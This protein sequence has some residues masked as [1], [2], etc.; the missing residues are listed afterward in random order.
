MLTRLLTP[1]EQRLQIIPE[2]VQ[3]ACKVADP[4]QT[5]RILSNLKAA[6]LGLHLRVK[7]DTLVAHSD[8]PRVIPIP[9]SI[10][11]LRA[12]ATYLSGHGTPARTEALAAAGVDSDI[13]AFTSDHTICDGGFLRYLFDRIARD[14]FVPPKLPLLPAPLDSLWEK[15]LAAASQKPSTD[16]TNL[17]RIWCRS[18]GKPTDGKGHYSLW[19]TPLSSLKC[20]NKSN[21]RLSGLTED[22]WM[23]LG[24]A[25]SAYN[26]VLNLPL[27]IPTCVDARAL[28]KPEA[29]DWSICNNFIGLSV[30]AHGL[31]PKSRVGDVGPAFRRDFRE[32]QKQGFFV[33]GNENPLRFG[34]LISSFSH[35][36]VMEVRPPFSDVWIQ[37]GDRGAWAEGSL[38]LLTWTKVGCGWADFHGSFRWP[39]HVMSDAE[40]QGLANSIRFALEKLPRET[41][42]DVAIR[43][44]QKIQS[45]RV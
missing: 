45:G 3:L 1:V 33:P 4:S 43:E 24:L 38:S 5:P 7:G 18:L 28:M 16:P 36:G 11:D 6:G 35:M 13:I 32:K 29:V 22:L 34:A 19:T 41:P 9:E 8:P 44:M 25:V 20:Y 39:P 42:V 12:A 10:R 14:D 15:E 26:S 23:A 17:T 2:F 37:N 40:G 21:G 30:F 27:G 31:T